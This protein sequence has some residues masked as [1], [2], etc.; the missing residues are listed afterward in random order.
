MKCSIWSNYYVIEEVEQDWKSIPYGKPLSNQQFYIFDDNF[1]VTP[2][3]YQES[4]LL[5]EKE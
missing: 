1:N 4:Y 3:W 5:E 2:C